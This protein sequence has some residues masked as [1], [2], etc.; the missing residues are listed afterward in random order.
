MGANK[1][2]LVTRVSSQ[3]KWVGIH[4]EEWE[5]DHLDNGIGGTV[6]GDRGTITLLGKKL[7]WTTGLY[8]LRWV[9][10]RRASSFERP[11]DTI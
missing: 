5:G 8:E 4:G 2:K 3:G 9:P 10:H 6:N 7:P 11:T 1:S